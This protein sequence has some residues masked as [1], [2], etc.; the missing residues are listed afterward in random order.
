MKAQ[1]IDRRILKLQKDLQDQVV[2]T[3]EHKE[4]IIKQC[5]EDLHEILRH[6][7]HRIQLLLNGFGNGYIII[8]YIERN[9]LSLKSICIEGNSVIDVGSENYNRNGGV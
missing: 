5:I 7:E 2:L 9:S 1:A 4:E 8:A 6:M 3:L